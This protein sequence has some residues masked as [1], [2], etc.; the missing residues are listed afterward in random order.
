[1]CKIKVYKTVSRIGSVFSADL[2]TEINVEESLDLQEI[3]EQFG[4]DLA[5]VDDI[6]EEEQY[7]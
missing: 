6:N 3:A 2:V 7:D 4:G 5:I 1:M